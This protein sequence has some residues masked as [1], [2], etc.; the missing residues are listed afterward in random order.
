[1]IQKRALQG[2]TSRVFRVGNIP[3][4]SRFS[5]SARRSTDISVLRRN[6]LETNKK[7]VHTFINMLGTPNQESNFDLPV[8]GSF[9]SC[10]SNALDHVATETGG[11]VGDHC[12]EK[13]NSL[14][15]FYR[16]SNVY[17][18]VTGKPDPTFNTEIIQVSLESGAR[19]VSCRTTTRRTGSSEVHNNHSL[20]SQTDVGM[21]PPPGEEKLDGYSTVLKSIDIIDKK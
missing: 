5:V 17:L 19:S 9:I 16:D 7:K 21:K 3:Q 2:S 12:G 6:C 8:I 4:V 13:K 1:M 18:S 10:K 11:R 20:T 14:S 15:T